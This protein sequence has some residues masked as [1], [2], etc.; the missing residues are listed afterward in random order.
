MCSWCSVDQ[1]AGL[2]ISKS[3]KFVV[4]IIKAACSCTIHKA[5]FTFQSIGGLGGGCGDGGGAASS[6]CD[7]SDFG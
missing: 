6:I 1:F 2:K 7:S 3:R 5:H 4:D